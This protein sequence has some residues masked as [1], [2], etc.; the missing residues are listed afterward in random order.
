MTRLNRKV[1]YA[2]MALKIMA[3]KRPGELT[4]AKEVA[5]KVGCPFDATARVLQRMAQHGILRSEQG[6][7]GGYTLVRDL[8]RLPLL[9][10][11]ELILGKIS[12]AKCMHGEGACEL[13]ASCNIV[14]PVSILNRKYQE[15]YQNICVGE[16]LRV[17]EAVSEV[18]V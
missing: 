7:H 6:A 5:D 12:A 10:L 9:E 3:G 14:T 2:L 13:E 4:S 8:S 18:R 1:E 11:M 15:F 16:L 17:K